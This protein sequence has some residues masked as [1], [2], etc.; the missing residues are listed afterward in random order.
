MSDERK[1]ISDLIKRFLDGTV[2]PYE[3]DDFISVRQR[4]AE[5]ELIRLECVNIR[6]LYP[7][8]SGYCS[9]TGLDR[10]KI[11]AESLDSRK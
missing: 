1:R 10:L 9:P 11:I 2:G 3:W 5:L 8:I 7:T 6:S 4:D